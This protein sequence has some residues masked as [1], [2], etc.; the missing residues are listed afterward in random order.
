MFC[1]IPPSP[2]AEN[3]TA[4]V[5]H[6]GAK[7]GPVCDDLIYPAS[8]PYINGTYNTTGYEFNITAGTTR[9]DEIYFRARF[10]AALTG[11][12]VRIYC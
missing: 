11:I 5:T 3:G 4:R 10:S 6:S 1:P 12:T 7:Y 9:I 2:P 8:C